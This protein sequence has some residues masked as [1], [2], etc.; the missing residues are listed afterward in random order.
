[1]WEWTGLLE[2]GNAASGSW[3]LKLSRREEED[4]KDEMRKDLG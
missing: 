1:M 2:I 4:L 3:V